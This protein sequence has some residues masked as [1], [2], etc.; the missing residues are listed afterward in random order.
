MIYTIE[1]LLAFYGVLWQR[2]DT[3]PGLNVEMVFCAFSLT[4]MSTLDTV[5][6]RRC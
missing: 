6:T 3:S 5:I 4:R 1:R 2:L